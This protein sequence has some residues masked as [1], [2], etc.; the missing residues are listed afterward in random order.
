MIKVELQ[1]QQR[2]PQNHIQ[3][4]DLV[5]YI[6]DVVKLQYAD[7]EWAMFEQGNYQLVSPF[8]K[9]LISC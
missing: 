4:M 8:T 2:S 9:H 6:H 3:L 1:V 7:L 5:D